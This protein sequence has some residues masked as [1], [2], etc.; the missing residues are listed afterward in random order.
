MAYQVIPRLIN[1]SETAFS[2]EL[3]WYSYL[4]P[5]VWMASLL[6]SVQTGTIDGARIG[7]IVC[8]IGMPL[9]SGFIIARYLAP[10]FSRFMSAPAEGSA[11]ASTKKQQIANQGFQKNWRSC[12]AGLRMKMPRFPWFGK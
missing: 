1:L 11:I 5:P 10:Y 7:M 12:C 9:L 3:H 8:A 4:L 6:D 2:F